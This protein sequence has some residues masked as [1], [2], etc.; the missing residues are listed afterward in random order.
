M[1]KITLLIFANCFLFFSCS[2]SKHI[3]RFQKIQYKSI[4]RG[5]STQILL[6]GDTLKYFQNNNETLSLIISKE[7]KNSLNKLLK[8]VHPETIGLIK[9]PTN[10]FQ[11]DGAMYTTLEVIW[12]GKNYKSNGFDDDNPPKKLSSFINFLLRLV[13]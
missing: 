1:K 6:Q 7:V 8:K 5:Y 2:S 4:T 10:K 9:A 3:D 11:Y 13:K 12:N